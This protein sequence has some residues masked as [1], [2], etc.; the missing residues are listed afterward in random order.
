[1]N[2]DLTKILSFTDMIHKF[3]A[4][5]RVIL[6]QGQDRDENDSEHSYTLA[7]LSWYINSTYKAG[8]DIDKL[9][10]Y[11]L[12]HDLVEVHAGDTYFYQKDPKV[13][14]D[15]HEREEKA[16]KQLNE[17]HPEFPELHEMIAAYEKREDQESKFIYALD[18]VEPMFSIYLDNGRTWNREKLTLEMLIE[19]KKDKVALDPTIQK[20]FNDMVSHLNDNHDELFDTK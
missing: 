20:I 5:E 14:Q 7:M 16:A 8:L 18:K 1:M 12:V 19:M 3:R 13:L 6:V 17:E 15:K 2:S 4:V 11:A 9:I 10:K